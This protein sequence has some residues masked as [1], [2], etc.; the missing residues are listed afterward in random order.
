MLSFRKV[1]PC[2]FNTRNILQCLDFRSQYFCHTIW[3]VRIFLFF[4]LRLNKTI[5]PHFWNGLLCVVH[6]CTMYWWKLSLKRTHHI[7]QWQKYVSGVF[8]TDKVRT[9]PVYKILLTTFQC[10]VVRFLYRVQ[11]HSFM[12]VNVY[13]S[14][15]GYFQST[16][17][18]TCTTGTEIANSRCCIAWFWNERLIDQWLSFSYCL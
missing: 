12:V 2:S 5:R 7:R 6:S 3:D 15:T 10:C 18:F 4:F 1:Y 13:D 14:D 8:Y 9:V 17:V 11:S 16:L